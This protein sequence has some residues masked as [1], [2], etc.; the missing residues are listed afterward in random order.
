MAPPGPRRPAG[1]RT[2]GFSG[3]R[4]SIRSRIDTDPPI[5]WPGG[6]D[7]P[8]GLETHADFDEAIERAEGDWEPDR[9]IRLAVERLVRLPPDGRFPYFVWRA[10]LQAD[11]RERV[12]GET[13]PGEL[14][15]FLRCGENLP[16]HHD[17]TIDT[18][19]LRARYW[20][21]RGDIDRAD[22]VYR[23][24]EAMDLDSSWHNSLFTN[25]GR[26]REAAGDC[27]GT[28]EAYSKIRG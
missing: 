10:A 8:E 12:T 3:I 25:M 14:F 13:E 20:E 26:N 22:T 4:T 1:S 28:L 2:R 23:H 18:I 15:D 6:I 9:G 21:R 27:D 5:D 16:P 17:G 19:F 24:L 7:L 11:W